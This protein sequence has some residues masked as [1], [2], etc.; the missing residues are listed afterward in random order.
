MT[1][2]IVVS[3]TNEFHRPKALVLDSVSSPITK[4]VYN[5]GLDEFIAWFGQEAR[6]G[7]TKAAVNAWR[8]TLESRGLGSVSINVR[9]T[10]VR[11]LAIEASDN[12][13]L[14]PELAA[15]ITRVKGAKSKGVRVGNWLSIQQAQKLLN[16]P[17]VTTK[18]GLRDRAM[19]AVLLGCGLRRSEVAA[20]TLKHIQQRDNRWCIVDLIGK[21]GRVRTIPVPTWVKV[22]VEIG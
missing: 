11:K 10:A 1:D 19:L 12:G 14:A 16:A 15:G 3:Q 17:D 8:V 9:I 6:P 2:L 21:H 4:R 7:F 13:L 18:K 22:A 20:L 5:L